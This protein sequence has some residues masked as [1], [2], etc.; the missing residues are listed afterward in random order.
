MRDETTQMRLVHALCSDAVDFLGKVQ[1]LPAAM[2][3]H[4]VRATLFSES[5][6]LSAT[7]EPQSRL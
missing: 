7:T 6:G 4:D 5:G 1:D 2:A 3:G